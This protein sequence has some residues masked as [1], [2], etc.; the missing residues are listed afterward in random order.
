[1]WGCVY[2]NY[3]KRN[4][5]EHCGVWCAMVN[6]PLQ[7]WNGKKKVHFQA[8]TVNSC[9]FQL[10][11]C[12]GM[13]LFSAFMCSCD[14]AF[15]VGSMCV[16][17]TTHSRRASCGWCWRSGIWSFLRFSSLSM[18]EFRTLSCTHALSRW[19]ARALSKL[20]SLPGPGFSP[21][22]SIQVCSQR[23]IILIIEDIPQ[24]CWMCCSQKI[25]SF[26]FEA[27]AFYIVTHG[28]YT[29]WNNIWICVSDY[30]LHCVF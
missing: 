8:K 7:A 5:G 11:K 3:L 9:W 4:H 29:L 15:L 6:Q 18:E 23:E 13:L 26:L 28:P 27:R 10:L 22:G 30:C 14:H 1:M 12:E 20:Q 25:E 21:E 19:W 17:P 2:V 16:C 24:P